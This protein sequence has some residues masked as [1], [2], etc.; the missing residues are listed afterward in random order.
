MQLTT[1]NAMRTRPSRAPA[2]ALAYGQTMIVTSDK[3]V[4]A[5]GLASG[6][7][8]WARAASGPEPLATGSD[9]IIALADSEGPHAGHLAMILQPSNLG[10]YVEKLLSGIPLFHQTV[11][12]SL[13]PNKGRGEMAPGCPRPIPPTCD[14]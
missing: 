6:L 10:L 8:L 14:W 2:Y 4:H 13:L 1:V 5:I 11:R 7:R 3:G 9:R 12:R